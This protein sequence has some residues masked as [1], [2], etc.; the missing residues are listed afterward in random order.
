M[1]NRKSNAFT[2]IELLIVVG[3][4]ALLIS[5]L[6]PSLASARNAAKSTVCLSNLK[7][8]GTQNMLY[9]NKYGVFPPVRLKKTPD[10][11]GVMQDFYYDFGRQFKRK[12]P[13]WQWFLGEDMGPVIDPD[14][15]VDE[16]AF[17]KSMVIDNPYWEDPAMSGF[18]ND[19]RNGAYGYNGTYLGYTRSMD[20]DGDG[21][22]DSWVRWPVG[23]S[24]VLDPGQT[25]LAAD[26]RGGFS[27]HGNH[28]YWLDP[29]KRAVYGGD[30]A[31]DEQD[32]SP[33]PSDPANKPLEVLGHSPVEARHQ[34]NGNV[35]FVDA[36]AASMKLEALGYQM[37]PL[38][39]ETLKI[40]DPLYDRTM[41]HNK[42][43]AGTGRDDPPLEYVYPSDP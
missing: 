27:P 42:L 41:N 43:W 30:P 8:I 29:P 4:I 2:L 19:V 10:S 26:S 20:T 16:I 35:V 18:T 28:S 36:H 25:V 3:I 14:K 6:L 33:D 17:N 13:R 39:G 38:T 40:D 34:R 22:D 12:G 31:T 32:F 1:K 15:Y 5:I 9:L 24:M 23:E 7:Q 37:D 11:D 21:L